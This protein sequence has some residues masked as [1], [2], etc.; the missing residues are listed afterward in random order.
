M[1]EF[2]D[3]KAKKDTE[4]GKG[5]LVITGKRGQEKFFSNGMSPCKSLGC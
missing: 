3:V 4:G 1:A 2:R 5:T